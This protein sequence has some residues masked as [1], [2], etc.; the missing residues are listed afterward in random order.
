MTTYLSDEDKEDDEE[1]DP[2]AIDTT[3][4][5]EWD[6]IKGVAMVHPGLSEANMSQ[7][8]GAP[9]K[10]RSKTR[11]RKKPVEDC[12][13]SGSQVHVTQ[14]TESQDGDGG[15]QRATGTVNVGEDLRCVPLLRERSESARPTVDARVTNGDDGNQDD[16]VH[17]VVET[18]QIG[19]EG[20]NN[21]WRGRRTATTD[22]TWLIVWN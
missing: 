20:S 10:E 9:G 11:K 16:N 22:Q 21:E 13:T 15:K 17:E 2:R 14:K 19:V 7:A 3:N 1:T 5:L 18:N 12:L 8:D 6:L 4:S